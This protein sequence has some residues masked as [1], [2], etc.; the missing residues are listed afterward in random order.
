MEWALVLALST[1][2]GAP[3][4][5]MSF[6]AGVSTPSK[7]E[8][9]YTLIA[10]DQYFDASVSGIRDYLDA[11][12]DSD[13]EVFAA[14]KPKADSLALKRN[15]SWAF[16]GLSLAV[17]G[18]DAYLLLDRKVSFESATPWVLLGSAVALG[19]VANFLLPDRSDYMSFV[20]AHNRQN[21]KTRLQLH[22]GW[23]PDSDRGA[24]LAM[25]LMNW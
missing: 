10:G 25:A 12:R 24:W 5:E 8:I 7:V 19:A 17:I 2:F 21:P 3:P 20:N 16:Y 13:P 18:V 4:T 15:F 14:M 23:I 11:I 6:G 1:L 9:P 22:I